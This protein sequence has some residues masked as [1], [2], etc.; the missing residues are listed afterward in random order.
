MELKMY[1]KRHQYCVYLISFFRKPI[2][3]KT[4][5]ISF[6]FTCEFGIT[7]TA[8]IMVAEKEVEKVYNSL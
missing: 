7:H 5:P 4:L 6:D 8:S 2:V 1:G 3:P